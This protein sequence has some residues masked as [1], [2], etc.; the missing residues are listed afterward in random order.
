MPC[1]SIKFR[2]VQNPISKDVRLEFYRPYGENEWMIIDASQ[3]ITV[4]ELKCLTEYL[5]SLFKKKT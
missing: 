1:D 5:I 4:Q 3:E 2:L